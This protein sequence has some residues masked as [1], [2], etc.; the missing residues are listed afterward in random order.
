ML[1]NL[2]CFS[3]CIFLCKEIVYVTIG[4]P[5]FCL[6]FRWEISAHSKMAKILDVPLMY[7]WPRSWVVGR[8]CEFCKGIKLDS[9]AINNSLASVY[10]AEIFTSLLVGNSA[11]SKK[12]I[13]NKLS[14]LIGQHKDKRRRSNIFILF[15][16]LS[17]IYDFN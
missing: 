16:C 14:C 7:L 13:Q 3:S 9:W 2:H 12:S 5:A 17:V 15:L 6:A 11:Y 10:S 8:N 4:K 1:G